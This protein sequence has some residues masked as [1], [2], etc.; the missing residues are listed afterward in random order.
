MAGFLRLVEEAAA[1]EQARAFLGGHLDISRRQQEHLVG[2]ALHA[3]VEGV[4]QPAREI[5]ES[6]REILIGAL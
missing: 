3:P 4:G 6:L 2:D 5:D 1:L